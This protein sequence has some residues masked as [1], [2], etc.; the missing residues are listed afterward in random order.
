MLSLRKVADALKLHHLRWQR[1]C[2]SKGWNPCGYEGYT[3]ALISTSIL[4]LNVG[5]HTLA[6]NGVS[7][8]QLLT[9]PQVTEFIAY[10]AYDGDEYCQRL[11]T[12]LALESLEQRFDQLFNKPLKPV[13]VKDAELTAKLTMELHEEVIKSI[14]DR[15]N[16]AGGSASQKRQFLNMLLE[17]H[18]AQELVDKE[19]TDSTGT[20]LRRKGTGKGRSYLKLNL[21]DPAH[22]VA[23]R[24]LYHAVALEMC[25]VPVGASNPQTLW[26]T[27][28]VT[29]LKKSKLPAN[30]KADML[31]RV[32]AYC[33]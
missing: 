7:E 2:K 22:Y 20:V 30:I 26:L 24:R 17:G 29:Q 5:E 16:R 18:T 10:Q 32:T 31:A 21:V 13:E 19:L 27:A 9:C 1:F 14:G 6:G 3:V 25:F 4:K 28:A 12:S 23:L 11:L 8:A 15:L 33:V